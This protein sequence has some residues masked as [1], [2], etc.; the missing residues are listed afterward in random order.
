MKRQLKRL[1]K[2]RLLYLMMV[3]GIVYLIF[4][5]YM[6]MTGIIIAF[7][8][9]NYQKG[10]WKSPWVGLDNFKYLFAT[11]DSWIII[12]N[13]LAYNLVFIVISVVVGMTLAILLD[14]LRSSRMKRAYQM[15]FLLPYMISIVVVSYIVYALLSTNTGFVNQRLLA[16]F[17][18]D[19]VSWYSEPKY[20][21]FILVLVNQ[22]KWLGYNCVI[23]YSSI[24]GIDTQYYESAII[25]GASRWQR[26][27][28][29]TIPLVRKTV[30]IMVLM[31]I[32]N[33]FRSDFGLFYQV[34]MNSSSLMD[35]TNTI[36]TYVYRGLKSINSLGM[37]SAAGVYQS[38]VG[39]VTVLA[40]NLVVR[41]IDKDSALF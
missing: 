36:D 14:Q 25:D 31:Q 35:V 9:Y 29:I 13:T 37:T 5:N 2:Y 41:K 21:P 33:I 22:W 10:I 12:R 27:T 11:R 20:W 26:I 1:K 40:A 4:N 16:W 32:G 8:K 7:K 17:G 6:P 15:L 34:P 30:I 3:P 23:Y 19:P 39:F 24:I 28:H 18:I 38:V